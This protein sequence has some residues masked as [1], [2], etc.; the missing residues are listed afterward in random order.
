[1]EEEKTE[2]PAQMLQRERTPLFKFGYREE[3]RAK[4]VTKLWGYE[5]IVVTNP[6][7]IGP[8]GYQGYTQ[9]IL[10][11]LP[12]GNACSIHYH[13]NKEE[14]FHIL[15]GCLRLI[16]WKMGFPGGAPDTNDIRKIFEKTLHPGDTV[17][18]AFYSPHQ[19]FVQ[20]AEIAEFLE[21]S[22]PDDPMD[23]WRIM[24]SGPLNS[25]PHLR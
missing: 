2:T 25:F 7:Y 8:D 9:K 19:F 16:I 21:C 14:T 23:S 24:P 15:R 3:E 22:T 20:G 10:T 17:T 1:M 5:R 13:Q 18:I 6:V 11:V 4:V 12:N